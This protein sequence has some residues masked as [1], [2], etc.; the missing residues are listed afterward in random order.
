MRSAG[1]YG[2]VSGQPGKSV[3]GQVGGSDFGCTFDWA[4]PQAGS[5]DTIM[6]IGSL[7]E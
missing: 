6:A 1:L 4:R 3:H 5:G 7:D 2:C